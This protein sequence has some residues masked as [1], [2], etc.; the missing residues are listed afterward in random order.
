MTTDLG[1]KV[2]REELKPIKAQFLRFAEYADL[3]K[4]H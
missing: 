2:N 1:E 3:K 4:L